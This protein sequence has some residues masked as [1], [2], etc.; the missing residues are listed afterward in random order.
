MLPPFRSSPHRKAATGVVL[1]L[2]AIGCTAAT[3]PAQ[4]PTAPAPNEFEVGWVAG[5]SYELYISTPQQGGPPPGV[6][7]DCT[8]PPPPPPTNPAYPNV[9][10]YAIAPV[11]RANPGTRGRIIKPPPPCYPSDALRIPVRDVVV[12]RAIPATAPANCFGAYVVLGS[13]ASRKNV[14]YR[15][16]PNGSGLQLAY[17]IVVKKKKVLLT[18]E[19]AIKRGVKLRLLQVDKSLGYGGT[20]WTGKASK[21]PPAAAPAQ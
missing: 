12:S 8:Q 16:D 18:S 15:K 7:I 5:K 1:S 10:V 6:K 14:L 11:D 19:A 17:A 4:A 2:V 13:R 3:A 9:N 20:C 21:T